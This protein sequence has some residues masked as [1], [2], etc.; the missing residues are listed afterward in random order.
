MPLLH[1][2]AVMMVPVLVVA[3]LLVLRLVLVRE[4][5]RLLGTSRRMFTRW[6]T[7]FSF[8]W[9]GVP[10]YGLAAVPVVGVV[11]AVAVFAGLTALVHH[12][13][14]WSLGRDKE[15]LP[16]MMWEKLLLAGLAFLTLVLIGLVLALALVLGWGVAQIVE[17]VRDLSAD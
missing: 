2:A 11:P 10:G 8:L 16:L 13:T 9:I 15:R 6:I 12:Y 5:R 4:A 7:R 1:V 3:H 17:L 14:L